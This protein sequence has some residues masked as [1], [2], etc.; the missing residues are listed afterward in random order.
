MAIGATLLKITDYPFAYSIG[1][2]V[3]GILGYDLS[4]EKALPFL[5][6]A[7]FGGTFLAIV[8]P[9]GWLTRN[10][11]MILTKQDFRRKKNKQIVSEWDYIHSA[12]YTN[13]INLEKDKI[14]S[15]VYFFIIIFIFLSAI[16]YHDSFAKKLVIENNLIN[17]DLDC[18]RIY[19]WIFLFIA[20]MII[21]GKLIWNGMQLSKKATIVATYLFCIGASD[22][23]RESVESINKFIE[24]GDWKTAE[25]WQEKIREDIKYK[26]GKREIVRK[27]ADVVFQLLHGDSIGIA[28]SCNGILESRRYY[29]ITTSVWSQMRTSGSHYMIEEIDLEHRIDNFYNMIED[30]NKLSRICN[31]KTAKLIKKHMSTKFGKEIKE[32]RYWTKYENSSSESNLESCALFKIHPK[33]AVNMDAKPLQLDIFFEGEKD[34]V[35]TKSDVDYELFDS[36]WELIKNDIERDADVL[37]LK[38]LLESIQLENTKLLKIYGEKIAMQWNV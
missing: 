15:I 29:G 8:D 9:L 6:L 13:S 24:L 31:D 36:A 20:A 28:S 37:K 25:Y 34:S 12:F 26:K 22:V 14:V 32:I 16:H 4:N 2:I 33:S 10:Y 18:V 5:A 27:S 3:I 35:T 21:S 38:N 23:P 1:F 11:F 17:C 30:Y 19:T 7:G